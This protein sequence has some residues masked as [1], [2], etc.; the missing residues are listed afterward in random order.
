[1]IAQKIKIIINPMIDKEKKRK[2]Q[3]CSVERK[4]SLELESKQSE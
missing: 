3:V 1:M 4:V 2:N